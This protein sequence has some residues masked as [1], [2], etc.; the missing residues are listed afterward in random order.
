MEQFFLVTLYNNSH[1]ADNVSGMVKLFVD[2]LREKRLIINDTPKYFPGLLIFN[3]RSLPRHTYE[4]IV[5]AL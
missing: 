5:I 3:D 1:D 2:T 4:F